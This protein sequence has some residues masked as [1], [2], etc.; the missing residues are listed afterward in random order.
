MTDV[1]PE[2]A[3]PDELVAGAPDKASPTAPTQVSA[4]D[5]PSL[6]ERLGFSWSRCSS[7][8]RHLPV[9]GLMLI[10]VVR[11]SDLTVNML[12]TYDQNAYDM[13]IP[14]QGIWLLSRFQSPFVTVM[15]KNLFGD[16]TSFIFLFLVPLDWIYPHSAALLVIQAVVIAAGAIP[17]YLLAQ[18]LLEN[19]V[20]ATCF[21]AAYLLSPAL[22][23]GNLE[24]FHVEA[25]TAPLLALAIYAAVLWRPRLLLV[26]IA[27]LLLT[28]QDV[29]LYTIPIGL[30][31]AFRRR[32]RLGT[33]IVAG[34]LAVGVLD[35]FVIIPALLG[36]IPTTYGGWIPFGGLHGFF[37]V[38]VHRPGQLW[39]YLTSQGRPWYLWQMVFSAGLAL[40]V[41]PEI[42]LLALLALGENVISDF[43]YQHKII[44]HYSMPPVAIL[45]CGSIYAVSR[46]S[47][48][49]RRMLAT[50][51]VTLCALWSCVL[52]GAMPFSVGAVPDPNPSLPGVAAIRQLMSVIPPDAVI[53]AANNYVPNLDH[54]TQVYLFPNPF[55]QAYY[56][57][58]AHNG[59]ELPSASH[60][61]YL[62]LPACISCDANVAAYQGVFDRF[63]SQFHEIDKASSAIL[64]ERNS[65]SR[66]SG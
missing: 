47:T 8:S 1:G 39:A 29:A 50:V 44:Y 26:A 19:T 28:K 11:F 18:H 25:F 38:M 32:A 40:L 5:G 2:L 33:A 45:V 31:V 17:I 35:N 49:R 22:Q 7:S 59:Q 56:G 20:L 62:L 58:P 53:S 4:I 9:V 46:F 41:A 34:S 15:G 14:D 43:P 3:L 24:Q 54:R 13:A 60:V 48:A 36:G 27:F 61:R 37:E 55:S 6:H 64:Y 52:W 51:G 12:R 65:H 30:W 21:A 66:S 57:D 23:Q 42:A 16:H 10:Y 63:K